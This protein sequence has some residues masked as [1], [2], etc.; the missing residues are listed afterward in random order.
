MKRPIHTDGAPKAIGPY[1]QAVKIDGFVYLS[2]Q[3]PLDPVTQQLVKGSFED[4]ANRVMEN[5]QAVL[6][7]AD[8]H[9]LDVI[10]TTIYLTDLSNFPAFNAVYEKYLHPPFPARSTVQVSAL[11][12][13]AAIEIEVIA[14]KQT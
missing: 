9:W 6:K 3:I 2:G 7:E 10:K 14:K 13:G 8:C 1:S 12:K 5:I 4:Q 11:P